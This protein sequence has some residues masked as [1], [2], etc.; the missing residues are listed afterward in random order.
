MHVELAILTLRPG[1]L[2]ITLLAVLKQHLECMQPF[3]C[4]ELSSEHAL[5]HCPCLAQLTQ[6]YRLRST[7]ALQACWSH[8]MT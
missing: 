8:M 2:L 1:W 4:C 6:C 5:P 7:C 3:R